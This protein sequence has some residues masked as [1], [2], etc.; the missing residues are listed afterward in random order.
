M[1]RGSFSGNA[2]GLHMSAKFLTQ[3]QL[4]TLEIAAQDWNVTLQTGSKLKSIKVLVN[5]GLLVFTTPPGY[6]DFSRRWVI[7]DRGRLA[8]KPLEIGDRV[9]NVSGRHGVIQSAPYGDSNLVVVQ[10]DADGKK[11]QR[12]IFWKRDLRMELEIDQKTNL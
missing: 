5:A 7:T 8:I 3:T 10:W 11:R 4:N 6:L 12:G 2:E 9:V 1:G